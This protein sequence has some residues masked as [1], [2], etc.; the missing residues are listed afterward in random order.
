MSALPTKLT[1]NFVSSVCASRKAIS[2]RY[3]AASVELL[4]GVGFQFAVDEDVFAGRQIGRQPMRALDIRHR[5]DLRDFEGAQI[6]F[7]DAVVGLVI[8]PEPMSVVAAIGL[9]QHRM[10]RV[11]PDRAR[12]RPG[13]CR[14]PSRDCWRNPGRREVRKWESP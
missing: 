4:G 13:V 10:M 9:A 7:G 3:F 6:N 11:A 12:W 2:E 5:L 1:S 14:I 8:D